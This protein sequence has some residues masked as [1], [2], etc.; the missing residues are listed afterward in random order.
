MIESVRRCPIGCPT[1]VWY[2]AEAAVKGP[3]EAAN[4]KAGSN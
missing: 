1:G 3:H 4:K 2:R